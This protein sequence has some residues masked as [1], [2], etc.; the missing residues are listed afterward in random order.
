M[1]R[2]FAKLNLEIWSDPDFLDLPPAAQHLY[3]VLWTSPSLSYCGVHD[4][5]PGRLA[6]RSRGFTAEHVQTVADCLV[7]RHFLVVDHDTEEVLVR[8]W[9]RFDGIMKQPRMAVSYVHAYAEVA[10]PALR[11]VLVHETEKIREELPGLACWNDK[12]VTDILA[13]PSVS[14]KDLPTP[15]DP[16]RDGVGDDFALGLAQTRGRVSTRVST[17][18]TTTTT[19]T[20]SRRT[21]TPAD[22]DED[23][24]DFWT[25]Y[26]RKVAKGAARKA[27]KSAL[28]KT[29]AQT[30]INGAR[31]FDLRVHGSDPKF[32][33]HP[34]SWLHGERWTD[35]DEQRTDPA[36]DE[37]FQPFT[38][39]EPP[40]EVA[41]DPERYAT[42]LE[43]Q[44]EA[45]S[46]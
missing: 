25:R 46:R 37:W 1:P 4:W 20:T 29:D 21:T 15:E 41:D 42:W 2:E 34:A 43:Q 3:L 19:T 12:R 11:R 6:K 9:A 36:G 8:S 10:S 35:E 28:K 45:W 22:A 5:R 33:P 16:F 30:I 14:A 44:R 24:D 7:A 39:P 38:P 26:P 13:H 31:C 27:W 32:I 18:P 23:F 17:P 40:P